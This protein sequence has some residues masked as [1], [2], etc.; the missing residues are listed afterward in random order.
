MPQ[1][2]RAEFLKASQFEIAQQGLGLAVW[3]YLG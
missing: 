1:G 2:I 3:R